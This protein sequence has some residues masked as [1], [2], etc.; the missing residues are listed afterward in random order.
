MSG[1]VKAGSRWLWRGSSIEVLE[2]DGHIA[3]AVES[4]NEDLVQVPIRELQPFPVVKEG[5]TKTPLTRI[6]KQEWDR[7]ATLARELRAINEL[8]E[9]QSEAVA[10]LAAHLELSVRT[11]WR[12]LQRFR[13]S[14]LTTGLIRR[15]PG[16]K[17]GCRV[18]SADIEKVIKTKIEE[19]YLVPE[20]PPLAELWR[21]IDAFCRAQG[22]PV[23]NR[24]TITLR[25]DALDLR[26]KL[27]HRN[28]KKVAKEACDP[29]PGH[30]D[31]AEPLKRVEIDHTQAD[32]ILRAN[33]EEREV[34]GRPWITLAIDCAT[35]MV[36]GFYISFDRP[37]S[38]SVALCLTYAALQ[39]ARFLAQMGVDGDW[40]AQGKP[41]EIWVDN[42]M[43]FDSHAM[44]RGCEEHQIGL[45]FRPVGSPGIG[46]TIERLIGT[47]MG[48]CHLLPGTTSSN[49]VERGDYDAEARAVMTLDEF[50][51]W[52]TE[53][54]VSQYH[55]SVHRGLGTSPLVA[56]RRATGTKQPGPPANAMEYMT[57]FLPGDQRRLTRTGVHI[58]NEDYWSDAFSAWVGRKLSVQVSYHPSWIRWVF[59]RLPDGMVVEALATKHGIPDITVQDWQKRRRALRMLALDA[60]HIEGR[61]KG[62]ARNKM[63]VQDARAATSKALRAMGVSTPASM[64]SEPASPP[65][66]NVPLL[67][68]GYGYHVIEL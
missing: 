30:L 48:H 50:T 7:A 31:V 18:L 53:Q 4:G 35:R 66:S 24:R 15:Q 46:G 39:K 65:P 62:R 64:P 63:R 28:G 61:D 29:V 32:V 68:S 38:A 17:N 10:R 2:A 56:W 33:T 59:V 47:V 16:R 67:P 1:S 22:L 40:P 60:E 55:L 51:R 14:P 9:G 57:A 37:S 27:E 43:E 6:N 20:R 34:I 45:N 54:V 3:V 42:A 44:K 19:V 41:E 8:K 13:K 11:V 49:V 52:F 5:R 21:E 25:V 36:I 23:P 26:N 12:S 58:H